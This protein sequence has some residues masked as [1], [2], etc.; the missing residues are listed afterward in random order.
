[1]MMMIKRKKKL[2]ITWLSVTVAYK[3]ELTQQHFLFFG[4]EVDSAELG[5]ARASFKA[6][7]CVKYVGLTSLFSESYKDRWAKAWPINDLANYKM[8][9]LGVIF[10]FWSLLLYFFFNLF[11]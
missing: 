4:V 7:I 9:R 3:A 2:W 11:V 10:V 8:C 1:M 6:M 5:W